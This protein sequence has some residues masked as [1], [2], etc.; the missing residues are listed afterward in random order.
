MIRKTGAVLLLVA[1]LQAC[2]SSGPPMSTSTSAD[3]V[4]AV[5]RN[6]SGQLAREDVV[7]RAVSL[8]GIPYRF[9]GARP[10]TG[11]DCSGLIHFV[12]QDSL[13]MTLPRTTAGL[14][15]LRSKPA[16]ERLK[17]GDLVLFAISGRKVNHAGIYVGEGRFL[18]APSSGGHVRIDELQAS[19][20]QRTYQGA[21]R[22][23][24]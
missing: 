11:F 17:P 4:S 12:Y 13:G 9:G 10:E 19:Y 14:N 18:H 6:T 3:A 16:G 20:W 1:L 5:P 21:R 23:L 8:V 15:D 7:F 24:D 22:V 2:A